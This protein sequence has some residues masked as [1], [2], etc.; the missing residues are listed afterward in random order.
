MLNSLTAFN[1]V[2]DESIASLIASG[3]INDST[4]LE[5]LNILN[6]KEYNNAEELLNMIS[7]NGDIHFFNKDLENIVKKG[8][9]NSD[10]IES[11]QNISQI[12]TKSI[13]GQSMSTTNVMDIE[14]VIRR[15]TLKEVLLRESGGGVKEGINH[16]EQVI[17]NSNLSPEQ[18]KNLRYLGN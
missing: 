1:Q 14:Q 8:L 4:A 9:T 12:G 13:L 11:M 6:N 17:Q 3:N 10:Y 7:Q 16:F 15:E 18:S 2:S 5:M